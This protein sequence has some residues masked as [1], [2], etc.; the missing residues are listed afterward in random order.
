MRGVDQVRALPHKVLPSPPL[1]SKQHWSLAHLELLQRILE[2]I[3]LPSQCRIPK[4]KLQ[5]TKM[6]FSSPMMK[7]PLPS[8][9]ADA[10]RHIPAGYLEELPQHS[11]HHTPAIHLEELPQ[12]SIHHIP[13]ALHGRG[14][15][16]CGPL[17]RVSRQFL[18][19]AQHPCE[20]PAP[21]RGIEVSTNCKVPTTRGV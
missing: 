14:V 17:H 4:V 3:V 21:P 9:H 19:E 15:S 1:P 2:S 7:P 6:A 5:K 12:H 11:I 16:R 8:S 13:A 10:A 18:R 20:I